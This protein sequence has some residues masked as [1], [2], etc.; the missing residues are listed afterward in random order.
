MAAQAVGELLCNAGH[1]GEALALCPGS[2]S[3]LSLPASVPAMLS[4]GGAQGESWRGGTV[5]GIFLS[6]CQKGDKVKIYNR[7]IPHMDTILK[8]GSWHR[9]VEVI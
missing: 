7:R 6:L 1:C 8:K 3:T 5:E 9:K 4:G 2:A